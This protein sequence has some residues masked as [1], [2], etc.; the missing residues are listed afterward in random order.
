M[1]EIAVGRSLNPSAIFTGNSDLDKTSK[2]GKI[3]QEIMGTNRTG[4]IDDNIHANGSKRH[5]NVRIVLCLGQ[6]ILLSGQ[7]STPLPAS[8]NNKTT[9]NVDPYRRL[10]WE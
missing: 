3:H 10:A 2:E 9:K 1:N 4:K 5:P 7:Y 8:D 6:F